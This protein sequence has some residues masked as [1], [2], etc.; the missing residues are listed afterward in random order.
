MTFQIHALDQ[1]DFAHLFDLPETELI[2][3]GI[4]RVVADTNP[5]YPCRVS[6][7]DAQI[8]EDLLLLNHHHLRSDGP[9]DG[10]HAIYVRRNAITCTPAPGDVPEQLSRRLLSVRGFGADQ[11]MRAAEVVQGTGLAQTL[12]RLLADPSISFVDIHNAGPGCYAARATR[13]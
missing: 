13:A 9:Y 2:R 10:R 8:G 11:M 5:G 7:Q 6:L 4:R 3:R 12:H 1:R